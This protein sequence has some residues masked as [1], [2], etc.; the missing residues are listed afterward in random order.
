MRKPIC[1]LLLAGS[2]PSKV[3]T[4]DRNICQEQSA[5][6]KIDNVQSGEDLAWRQ[7][8]RAHILIHI[9]VD[10]GHELLGD[11]MFL[12]VSECG[13]SLDQTC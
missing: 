3:G 1:R 6:E 11:V 9:F 13:E 10:D 5:D 4:Y 8:V 2:L 12:G 7:C